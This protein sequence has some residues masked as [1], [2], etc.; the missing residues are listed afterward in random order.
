VRWPAGFLAAG[1]VVGS[2]SGCG[3]SPS[4]QQDRI[5]IQHFSAPEFSVD[6]PG[7]LRQTKQKFDSAAGPVEITKYSVSFDKSIVTI[8]V[9]PV[10]EGA[11]VDLDKAAESFEAHVPDG[12]VQDVKKI[13]YEGFE[14]RDAR[15]TVGSYETGFS[16]VL[17]IHGSLLELLDVV[18]SPDL[19]TPPDAW[20]T[21]LDSLEIDGSATAS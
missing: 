9:L 10:P 14:G 19:K 17:D 11:H 13:D 16:R 7:H 4:E 21:M 5:E 3:G 20:Q 18:K 6:V 1:L 2:L 12:H 15:L 8:F